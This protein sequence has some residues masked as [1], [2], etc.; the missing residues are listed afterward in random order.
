M[1]EDP[2]EAL[3]AHDQALR[4]RIQAQA[5]GLLPCG[6]D[7]AGRGPLAGPVLA[8]AVV[9]PAD[10][11]LPGL[12]DSKQLRGAERERL[13]GEIRRQA[14]AWAIGRAEV[15]EIDALGIRRATFLAMAR[16]L[17]GVEVSAPDGTFGPDGTSGLYLLVDGRDFPFPGRPG[18]ALVRGDGQSACVAA[19]GILAKVERDG[20]LVR[21]DAE[22]PG[23]GFARHKGYGTA[24]HLALLKELGRLP[25]HRRSFRL[26]WEKAGDELPFP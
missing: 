16:A 17:A 10:A 25:V 6:V 4:E 2:F 20:E 8:G 12:N 22:F 21:L 26:P 9:L 7:E 14:L 19:A 13:A 23:W 3:K 5:P 24:A 18:G 1:R 15:E 11:R